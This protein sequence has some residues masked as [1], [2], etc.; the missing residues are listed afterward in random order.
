[1]LAAAAVWA[2]STSFRGVFVFD[3]LP[4]IV[5]NQSI[6]TLWPPDRWFSA[7]AG[8][9]P[10]GRPVLNFTLAA[11]YAAGGLNPLGYHAVSL[12]VTSRGLAPSASSGGPRRHGAR[13]AW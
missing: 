4:G 6:R 2:Y 12:A 13:S 3:D 7:P 10:S 11:N 1:M 9:T 8:S 5:R